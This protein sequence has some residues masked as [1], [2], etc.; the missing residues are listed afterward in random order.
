VLPMTPRTL[1]TLF[2][3]Q[4]RRPQQ[5]DTR[6]PRARDLRACLRLGAR[7]GR[8]AVRTCVAP[9]RHAMRPP[10]LE[11]DALPPRRVPLLGS[12]PTHAAEGAAAFF[13]C[14]FFDGQSTK[15]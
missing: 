2:R 12:A 1:R 11:R 9:R 5:L 3:H 13:L 6:P 14:A 8:G 10:P 15:R 7:A 4:S